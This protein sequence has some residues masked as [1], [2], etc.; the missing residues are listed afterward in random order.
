MLIIFERQDLVS[1]GNYLLSEERK[2]R[3][4]TN[5]SFPNG[6]LLQERLEQVSHADIE[7]WLEENSEPFEE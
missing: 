1:F 7:N 6:E 3:I 5:E 2:E 4:H